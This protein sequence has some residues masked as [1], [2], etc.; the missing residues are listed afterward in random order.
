MI[1][2]SVPYRTCKLFYPI[3]VNVLRLFAWNTFIE[4]FSSPL[5]LASLHWSIDPTFWCHCGRSIIHHH[6]CKT[7]QNRNLSLWILFCLLVDWRDGRTRKSNCDCRADSSYL[8]LLSGAGRSTRTPSLADLLIKLIIFI[9]QYIIFMRSKKKVVCVTIHQVIEA[10]IMRW[11][12]FNL[13]FN[14][15]NWNSVTWMIY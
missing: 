5:L 2:S 1:I 4:S 13:I 9:C 6:V 11:F 14:P 3:W 10:W 8:N 12:N 15:T 7:R